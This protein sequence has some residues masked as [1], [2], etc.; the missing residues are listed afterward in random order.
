MYEWLQKAYEEHSSG[1]Q[2]LN[3]D[4]HFDSIRSDPKFQ[5]WLRV[6]GLPLKS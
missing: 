2:F 3:V 1:M 4:A 6:L 5:Y